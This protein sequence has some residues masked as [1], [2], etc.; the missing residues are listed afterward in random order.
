[1]TENKPK[2]HTKRK[3][4][5]YA[6][7]VKMWANTA[8]PYFLRYSTHGFFFTKKDATGWLMAEYP[9]SHMHHRVVEVRIEE[10]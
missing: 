5:E 4:A 7:A 9:Q 10:V 1:M 8:T 3:H 2:N 6:W